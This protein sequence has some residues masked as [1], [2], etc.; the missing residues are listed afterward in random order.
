MSEFPEDFLDD[1]KLSGEMCYECLTECPD[2]AAESENSERISASPIFRNVGCCP[3]LPLCSSIFGCSTTVDTFKRAVS[4]YGARPF[5]GQRA[6]SLNRAA[7]YR[8]QTYS[9]VSEIVN[10]MA[11]SISFMGL[12]PGARIGI[13]GPNCPEW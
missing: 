2:A 8:W 1:E 13:L 12:K 11:M 7:E 9:E 6:K 3:N 5:L 10:K 4:L